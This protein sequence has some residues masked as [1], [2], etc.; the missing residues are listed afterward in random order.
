MAARMSPSMQAR[1]RQLTGIQ[2]GDPTVD[3][4]MAE[5]LKQNAGRV[6]KIQSIGGGLTPKAPSGMESWWSGVMKMFAPKPKPAA[7][8]M[9]AGDSLRAEGKRLNDAYLGKRR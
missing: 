6:L 5:T 9:T 1:K 7:P 2:A 3:P 8:T 4:E